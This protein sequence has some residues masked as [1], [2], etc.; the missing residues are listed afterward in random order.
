[1]YKYR[2][3]VVSFSVWNATCCNDALKFMFSL[4]LYLQ[5]ITESIKCIN[6]I[7]CNIQRISLLL[8]KTQ[9]CIAMETLEMTC[10]NYTVLYCIVMYCIVLYCVCSIC[11]FYSVCSVVQWQVSCP[12]VTWQNYGPT[13]WYKY[14]CMYEHSWFCICVSSRYASWHHCDLCIVAW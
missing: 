12:T 8:C 9:Y 6:Y 4:L 13:K 1:M 7:W 2:I 14:V 5:S 11:C 10:V 3:K